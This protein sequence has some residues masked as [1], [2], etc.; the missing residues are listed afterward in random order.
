MKRA[1]PI[2]KLIFEM[3]TVGCFEFQPGSKLNNQKMM[4]RMKKQFEVEIQ[5]RAFK[6]IKYNYFAL[7]LRMYCIR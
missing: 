2:F 5:N 3:Y 4:Q 7:Y 6:N 1:S